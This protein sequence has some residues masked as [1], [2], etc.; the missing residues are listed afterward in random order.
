MS[1]ITLS[2]CK[3][4]ILSCSKQHRQTVCKTWQ[5]RVEDR[6]L[7]RIYS[8]HLNILYPYCLLIFPSAQWQRS[9][10]WIVQSNHEECNL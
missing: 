6:A 3:E 8:H 1:C 9:A 4:V 10:T 5:A 7:L 2:P